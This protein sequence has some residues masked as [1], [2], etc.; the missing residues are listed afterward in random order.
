M[1]AML[2][3]DNGASRS[4]TRSMILKSVEV[5]GNMG[6]VGNRRVT[7][8]MTKH[9]REYNSG[10]NGKGANT[11]RGQISLRARSRNGSKNV[12]TRKSR[13]THIL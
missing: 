12:S 4:S 8:S 10:G 2:E 13:K 9:L 3:V 1:G 7:R 6:V 11:S 5:A